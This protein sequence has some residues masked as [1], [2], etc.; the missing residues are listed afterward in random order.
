MAFTRTTAAEQTAMAL[1]LIKWFGGKSGMSESILDYFPKH[2]TYVEPFGGSGAVLLRKS[3]SKVECYNDLDGEL[4]NMFRVIRDPELARG[5]RSALDLTLY[6][7]EEFNFAQAPCEEPIEKARRFIVR[8]RQSFNGNGLAWGASVTDESQIAGWKSVLDRFDAVRRRI[9]KVAIERDD[10]TR[11]LERYDTRETLFY[12]D[13]PYVPET[14]ISGGYKHEMTKNQHEELVKRL[15]SLSGHVVLS[16]Y[17]S[18]VYAP[19]LAH[20]WRIER[21]KT[22]SNC[23]RDART[24]CLW[25]SPGIPII[26]QQTLF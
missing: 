13:P 1:P 10:Y 21:I 16:G 11:I 24:E 3:P 18:D 26:R 5:L 25:L 2:T 17:E 23:S 9:S 14:R 8:Q 22:H 7:R 20:A 15:L 19:L 4:F 12:M 6:S